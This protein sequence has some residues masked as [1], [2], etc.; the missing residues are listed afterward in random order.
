VTATAERLRA[1]SRWSAASR[2][3]RWAALGLLGAE[4]SEA[5]EQT[6]GRWAR[7]R[8][9]GGLVADKLAAKYGEDGIEREREVP[10]PA[11][12]LHTDV[13]VI[14]EQRAIE[15]KSCLSLEP[16][17]EMWTQLAGE[18]IFDQE[19]EEGALWLIDPDT[20]AERAMPFLPTQEW[21]DR[22]HGIA[23]DV[24]RA[25]KTEV[26]PPCTACTPSECHFKGCPYTAIAW[27]G[28]EPPAAIELEGEH[29]KLADELFAAERAMKGAK[30]IAATY[31]QERNEI[32]ERLL[33]VLRPGVEH[34]AGVLRVRVTEVK[35]RVTY[36]ALSMLAGGTLTEE[37]ALPFRKVGKPSQR[38]TVKQVGDGSLPENDPEDFGEVPPF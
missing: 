23:D 22:V 27:E 15:V 1:R 6:K 17:D 19:A 7:G 32:R 33:A 3:P 20:M 29:A 36:D 37:Q 13:Y 9:F 31:E 14:E 10:W 35:P 26:L 24:V 4:P 11:G 21:E 2:C 18:V 5:D 8:L 16:T 30:G 25:G 34:R 38:W 28:W 12:E